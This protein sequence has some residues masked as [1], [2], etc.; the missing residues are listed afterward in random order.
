MGDL[1]DTRVME[2]NPQLAR[3]NRSAA[4]SIG[5]AVLTVVAFCVGAAPIPLT[6]FV[7][8]PTAAI[9]GLAAVVAGLFARQQIRSSAERGSR[10]ALAGVGIGGIATIA[11]LC[12]LGSGIVLLQRL[13][14]LVG[15]SAP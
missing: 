1:H 8:F 4:I 13:L 12:M 10:L 5:A 9:L 6:G 3:I 2:G 7:C 15:P 14:G 11:A